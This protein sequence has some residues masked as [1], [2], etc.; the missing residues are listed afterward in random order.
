MFSQPKLEGV[1]KILLYAPGDKDGLKLMQT[2]L[3]ELGLKGHDFHSTTDND[4]CWKLLPMLSPDLESSDLGDL[5][6]NALEQVNAKNKKNKNNG[7]NGIVFLGMD[8]PELSLRDIVSGLEVTS[9]RQDTAILCPADD[10]G[11]GMLCLPRLSSSSSSSAAAAAGV[12]QGVCWS[13][14]LTAVSQIKAL[15]D[16]SIHVSIGKLMHDIDEPS[17]VHKL[18]ERLFTETMMVI[19]TTTT[20]TATNTNTTTPDTTA[21]A[22]A[23]MVLDTY[24]QSAGGG[25]S[26]ETDDDDD[27]ISHHPVCQFTRKALVELNMHITNENRIND[28]QN[29]NTTTAIPTATTTVTTNNKKNYDDLYWDELPLTVQEA[30]RELGYTPTM[31]NT[32][33]EPLLCSRSWNELSL[34][35]R[36]AAIALGYDESSWDEDTTDGQD[37]DDDD[38]VARENVDETQTPTQTPA[39]FYEDHA[40]NELPNHVRKAA[41]VLG[42]TRTMWNNDEDSKIWKK[43]WRQLTTKQRN[44]AK[45]L[46][47]DDVTWDD[48]D[49]SDSDGDSESGV[50]VTYDDYDWHEL[51]MDVQEAAAVLGYTATMWDDDDENATEPES[52]DKYWHQLSTEERQAAEKIGYNED[53]WNDD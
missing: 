36:Q 19:P 22:A 25:G 10:G 13:N 44:A 48:D 23:A 41:K 16:Q 31:W 52:C 5:L 24:S 2:I 38:I 1:D 40:W 15:T 43:D 37:D 47:Y 30:A 35:K 51:P 9:L 11:Y 33:K 28:Q 3:Q 14:P 46:G 7:N 12:F 50:M 26:V 42:Y 27:I 45:L 4:K 6:Q 32:D 49:S 29:D 53:T 17:D 34:E 39:G 8:S 20:N 18:C 21:A